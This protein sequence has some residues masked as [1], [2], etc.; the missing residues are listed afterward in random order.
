MVKKLCF[1]TLISFIGFLP[2]TSSALMI[3]LDLEEIIAHSTLV[4]RGTVE[5][6]SYAWNEDQ[7]AIFTYVTLSIQE[8]IKGSPPPEAITIRY[9]GGAIG[10]LR[11]EIEDTPVFNL[12]EDVITFLDQKTEPGVIKICGAFQGKYTIESGV[13]KENNLPV[14]HFINTIKVIAEQIERRER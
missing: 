12:G 10:G 5:N 2:T 8:P 6:I 9:M 3:K 4:I 11:L 7:T 13:V 1:V 14:E